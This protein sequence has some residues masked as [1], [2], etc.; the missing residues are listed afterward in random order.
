MRPVFVSVRRPRAFDCIV[1]APALQF[2]HVAEA[3]VKCCEALRE[4]AQFGDEILPL[5]VRQ[6]NLDLIPAGPIGARFKP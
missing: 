6:A 5:G 3:R 4:G 2:R 1:G